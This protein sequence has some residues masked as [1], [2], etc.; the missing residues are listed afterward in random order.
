MYEDLLNDRNIVLKFISLITNP[1]PVISGV[2]LNGNQ[3][4]ISP[5]GK[6]FKFKDLNQKLNLRH[7]QQ[8][9]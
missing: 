5:P 7:E 2:F 4:C 9:L 1:L 8:Y 3:I 6:Y